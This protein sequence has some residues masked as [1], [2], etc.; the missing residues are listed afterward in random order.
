MP[1]TNLIHTQLSPE[2]LALALSKLHEVLDILKPSTMDITPAE[3]KKYGRIREH[4]KL[5]VQK[6][7]DYNKNQPDMSSPDIDWDK[8]H[9]SWASRSGFATIESLCNILLEACS[10]PRILHDYYLYDTAMVEY[11]YTKYRATRS[12]GKGGGFTTKL[13]SIKELFPNK[14]GRRGKTKK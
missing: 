1:L 7:L 3:R 14:N 13:E 11:N 4:K 6:V 5:I 8:F 9:A 10:D 12:T 2:D